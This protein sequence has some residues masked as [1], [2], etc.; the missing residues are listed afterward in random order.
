MTYTV[1]IVENQWNLRKFAALA[2]EIRGYT[3][4]E[5]ENGVQALKSMSTRKVDLVLTDWSLPEMNGEE[6]LGRIRRDPRHKDLPVVVMSRH[7]APAD[8]DGGINALG[9]M[10]WL[11][12]PCLISTLQAVIS[13]ILKIREQAVAN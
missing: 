8:S 12:K 13:D 4:L 2:L 7:K 5:A 1:L 9:I 11:R 10:T 6:L 3:I